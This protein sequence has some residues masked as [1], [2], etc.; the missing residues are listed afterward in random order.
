MKKFYPVP[1]AVRTTVVNLA[2][3]NA[4]SLSREQI[5]HVDMKSVLLAQQHRQI[6]QPVVRT[7]WNAATSALERVVSVAWVEFI[8]GVRTGASKYWFVL[9]GTRHHAQNPAR[10]VGCHAKTVV[11]IRNVN[12]PAVSRASLAQKSAIG[13][14]DITV[15]ASCVVSCAIAQDVTGLAKSSSSAE[16]RVVPIAAEVCVERSAFVPSARKTMA[17]Q[18]PKYF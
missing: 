4:R 15:V 14:A 2:Q 12:T 5:G 16:V 17:T 13:N 18:S 8:S 10:H 6:A 9:M 7:F 11:G 1:T 3:E